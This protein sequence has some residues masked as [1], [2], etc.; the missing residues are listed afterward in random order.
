MALHI[1]AINYDWNRKSKR[2]RFWNG[3]WM[4]NLKVDALVD[5]SKDVE[6]GTGYARL[7]MVVS[8]GRCNCITSYPWNSSFHLISPPLLSHPSPLKLTNSLIY[9]TQI[10]NSFTQV[11][12][13]PKRKNAKRYFPLLEKIKKT[14]FSTCKNNWPW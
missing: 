2:R 8:H 7:L 11:Q 12:S 10:H 4:T 3:N 14:V 9:M 6:G 13:P 1:Y 5:R